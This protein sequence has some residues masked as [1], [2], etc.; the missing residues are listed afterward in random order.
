MEKRTY[1]ELKRCQEIGEFTHYIRI[2]RF[3]R[4]VANMQGKYYGIVDFP[5]GYKER[6]YDVAV[7]NKYKRKASIKR[8]TRGL[9]V[10]MINRMQL[11]FSDAIKFVSCN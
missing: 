4:E 8:S 11:A 3:C 1:T 5:L 7:Q 2:I 6:T 9:Q 10:R